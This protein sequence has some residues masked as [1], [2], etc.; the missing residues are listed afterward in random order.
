MAANEGSIMDVKNALGYTGTDPANSAAAFRKD[1]ASLS[2][3]DKAQ[4]KAGVGKG[5]TGT[6]TY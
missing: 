6:M 5:G 2:D 1:W 4:L 3:T